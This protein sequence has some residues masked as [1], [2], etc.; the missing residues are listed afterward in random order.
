MPVLAT[1]LRRLR[2]LVTRSRIDDDLADEMRL[3][4]ELREERLRLEGLSPADAR[5]AAR[6]RFGNTLRLREDGLDT[7]GWRW[8]EQLGQ[9]LRFAAR[10]LARNPGYALTAI[11]TLALGIGANTAIFSAL[12]GVVLKPLPYT[13]GE[14]LVVIRQSAPGAAVDPGLSV[15]EYYDYR[16][17]TRSF[18]ALVEYHQMFFDL[19]RRGAP[20]RVD[21]GVVSHDFFDV[22]GIT[23]QLG[24]TFQPGDDAHGAAAVLVLGYSY[25]QTKF[26]G[27]PRIVGQVFEMNDR[28]HTVVGVLPNVP[29]YP[30]ENDVYMPVAACPF[31]ADAETDSTRDRRAF[32]ILSAF[33]RLKPGVT[34]ADAAHEIDAVGDRFAGAHTSVYPAR[35]QFSATASTVRDELVRDAEP[36]L[37]ILLGT[38]GLVLLAAC[39]NV[40]NLSIA[41]LLRRDRELGLREALGAERGRLVRQLLTESAFLSLLGG[42]LGLLLAASAM[43]LLTAFVGRFTSRT[44]EIA[45][46]GWVLGFTSAVS[47]AAGVAFGTV[48]AVMSRINLGAAMRAGHDVETGVRQRLQRGLIVA[49]VSVAMVLLTGAGLLLTSFYRLQSVDPGYQSDNVVAAEAFVTFARYDRLDQ[50]IG[51]YQS[52]VARLEAE[53]DVIA[54]AVTSAVP[55]AATEPQ[56]VRL[57]I[58]GRP[59]PPNEL[60]IANIAVA[61]P[62]YFRALGIPVKEGRGFNDND[63][64]EAPPVAIIN[65]ASRQRWGDAVALGSRIS[66]DGGTTWRTVVGIAGD[67]RQSSLDRDSQPLLYVPL[68]QGP[69]IN[70]RIVVR[71]AGDTAAAAAAIMR[72][73]HAVDPDLPVEN[74]TTL[75]DLR[76]SHLRRPQLTATLLTIFALLALV[77]TMTGIAGVMAMHV[78]KRMKEFGIRTALGA[79]P[80]QVLRPV[81]REGMQ[82]VGLGMILGLAAAAVLTRVLSSYLFETTTTDPATFAGVV[83]AL[84]L[85][86]GLACLGPAWRATRVD[87]QVV[88]RTE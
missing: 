43:S 53:P 77:V 58:E 17:G 66:F 28:P 86:G 1:I 21:V 8:L 61:T 49:Q 63:T 64:A 6:R 9:D 85:A 59:G 37:L 70:G 72:A 33:G 69:A 46:D 22:L 68:A 35:A 73:V 11:L 83:V 67:V 39:A 40:A 19:L 13:N 26:G 5:H 20:D 51:A 2:A 48:P 42:A 30:Q 75:N 79:S 78:T 60:A 36:L 38:T 81:L 41:R 44:G 65:E 74:I 3:H 27:D 82:L 50:F 47:I 87:P 32:Q 84:L 12:N 34:P 18:D 76:S 24:R 23:P 62:G 29:H 31:R 71:T 57:R 15:R 88:F 7:W 80:T 10:T 54:A 14:R 52:I 4:I 56:R 55:L 45:I 16:D 25:W